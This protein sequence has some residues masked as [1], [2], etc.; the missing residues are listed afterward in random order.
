MRDWTKTFSHSYETRENRQ[1][2]RERERKRERVWKIRMQRTLSSCTLKCS[3]GDQWSNRLV[4]DEFV[5][6]EYWCFHAVRFTF[7]RLSVDIENRTDISSLLW[8][9]ILCWQQTKYI[10]NSNSNYSF[11]IFLK[12][13]ENNNHKMYRSTSQE[14]SSNQPID[15]HRIRRCLDELYQQIRST[16]SRLIRYRPMH[17]IF[18]NCTN[19][20]VNNHD[21]IRTRNVLDR[22]HHLSI[23]NRM[24]SI[25]NDDKRTI[26]QLNV[27]VMH[28]EWKKMQLR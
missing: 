19:I 20:H 21:R 3:F 9:R 23:V 13:F 2:E 16:S 26:K 4:K 6:L 27:A 7:D 1:R 11:N 15:C 14:H 8:H 22:Q 25:G 5:L 18:D 10:N 28:D 17:I 24:M 12:Q